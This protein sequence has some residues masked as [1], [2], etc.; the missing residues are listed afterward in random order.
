MFW[1][2]YKGLRQFRKKDGTVGGILSISKTSTLCAS[3][4]LNDLKDIDL[5]KLGKLKFTNDSTNINEHYSY[6]NK[7][8]YIEEDS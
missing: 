2:Q 1:E 8:K 5:A 6:V 4:L 3:S 7:K